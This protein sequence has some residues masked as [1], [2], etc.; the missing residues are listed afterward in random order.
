MCI[1]LSHSS[2]HGRFGRS[3]KPFT[4]KSKRFSRFVN[5]KTCFSLAKSTVEFKFKRGKSHRS[6]ISSNQFETSPYSRLSDFQNSYSFELRDPVFGS[7]PFSE[8]R[9]FKR[10]RP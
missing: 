4:A 1:L 2:E 6:Q 9:R 5:W 8:F 3:P 7:L 10:I